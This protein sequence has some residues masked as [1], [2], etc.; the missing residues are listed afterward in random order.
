M[1]TSES[2]FS[3]WANTLVV[4]TG[5]EAGTFTTQE[6]IYATLINVSCAVRAFISC[7]SYLGTS[8]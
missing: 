1:N 6:Q 7:K 3:I 5:V 4:A 2:T 8:A